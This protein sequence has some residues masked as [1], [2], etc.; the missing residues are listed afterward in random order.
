MVA[1]IEQAVG[2]RL[3]GA[4][5][6]QDALEVEEPSSDPTWLVGTCFVRARLSVGIEDVDDLTEHIEEQIQLA[7]D[8]AHVILFVVD[9]RDGLVPLDEEVAKRLRY[10]KV[11]VLCVAN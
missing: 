1:S 3:A 4:L 11:P 7:V 6:I 2:D 9:T 10:V 8:S 5:R